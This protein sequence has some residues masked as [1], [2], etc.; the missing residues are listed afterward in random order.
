[1]GSLS[2]RETW[3][4][5]LQVCGAQRNRSAGKCVPHLSFASSAPCAKL[6]KTKQALRCVIVQISLFLLESCLKAFDIDCFAIGRAKCQAEY[7]T[8]RSTTFCNAKLHASDV[9][10][11]CVH[12]AVARSSGTTALSTNPK[13]R[14]RSRGNDDRSAT[15]NRSTGP[16]QKFLPLYFPER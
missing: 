12:R 8:L 11:S 14:P 1:M 7:R 6:H 4:H 13:I 2:S 15:A 3:R 9:S 5:S 16:F 10:W